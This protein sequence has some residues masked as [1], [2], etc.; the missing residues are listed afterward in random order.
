MRVRLVKALDYQK[1]GNVAPERVRNKW[2]SIVRIYEE[3]SEHSDLPKHVELINSFINGKNG[4]VSKNQ[5]MYAWGIVEGEIGEVYEPDTSYDPSDPDWIKH[6]RFQDDLYIVETY[7]NSASTSDDN[8]KRKKVDELVSLVLKNGLADMEK[9]YLSSFAERGFYR[10]DSNSDKYRTLSTL[11]KYADGGIDFRSATS[12]H[13][14][15][16][17]K[18]AFGYLSELQIESLID[19]SKSGKFRNNSK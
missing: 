11:K 15:S 13:D 5:L 3:H 10:E 14:Q 6:D 16:F 9:R 7:L 1:E 18:K 19:S 12:E 2:Y 17:L 4:K 8:D